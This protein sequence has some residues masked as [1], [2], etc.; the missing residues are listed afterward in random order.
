VATNVAGTSLLSNITNSVTPHAATGPANDNFANAQVIGAASGTVTAT[1]VGA[2]KEV[3]EPDHAGNPGGAS[4]W[5]VWTAPP[6]YNFVTFTTCGSSV[7]TLLGEYQGS[8]VD[9]LAPLNSAHANA[10]CPGGSLQVQA[11]ISHDI[12]AAGG[13]TYYIAIDGFN[14]ATGTTVL[15]WQA[16]NL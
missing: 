6:G 11:S 14:G 13:V 16:Q 3:G 10:T 2:S 5:Y 8:S 7:D 9:A 12:P 1:N 4:I 15:N